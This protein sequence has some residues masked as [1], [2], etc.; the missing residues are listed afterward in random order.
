MDTLTYLSGLFQAEAQRLRDEVPA[1]QKLMGDGAAKNE[2][3]GSL[4][5]M[6]D[7]AARAAATGLVEEV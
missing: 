6:A 7:R 4:E 3:A 1:G 5:R 2:L